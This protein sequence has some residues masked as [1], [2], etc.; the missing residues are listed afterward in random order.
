MAREKMGSNDGEIYE[1]GMA[2]SFLYFLL[3]AVLFVGSI[4]CLVTR[5]SQKV[6]F[7]TGRAWKYIFFLFRLPASKSLIP[8]VRSESK[9]C[10]KFPWYPRSTKDL[11]R[12]RFTA[13][14]KFVTTIHRRRF[15][16]QCYRRDGSFRRTEETTGLA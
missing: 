10:T 13:H 1:R 6:L 5:S 16:Q 9:S 7:P 11:H 14:R 3:L 15:R 4:C 8:F 2:R 12:W